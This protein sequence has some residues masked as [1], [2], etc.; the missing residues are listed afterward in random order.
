MF[1]SWTELFALLGSFVASALALVRFALVQH[2][3]MLDQFMAFIV[4]AQTRQIE[5]Q[6]RFEGA[7]DRLTENVRENSTLL[8][9]IAERM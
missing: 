4:D 7:L 6:D 5:T 1:E 3:S 8:T 9:R 2:R